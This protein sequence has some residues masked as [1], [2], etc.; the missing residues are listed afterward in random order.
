MFLYDGFRALLSFPDTPG[1]EFRVKEVTWPELEVGSIDTTVMHNKTLRTAAPKALI[2]IGVIKMVAQWD[3][4]LW[5]RIL[6]NALN[7]TGLRPAGGGRNSVGF[8]GVNQRILLTA[9]DAGT[10]TLYGWLNKITPSQFK[11]G[12]F[13]T[14]DMEVMPSNVNPAGGPYIGQA[15]HDTLPQA[16]TGGSPVEVLA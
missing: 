6:T 4:A 1:A 8:L 9:P 7:A 15:A 2:T 12:E 3:V 11:E 16:G 5:A 14:A 10:L 13:P